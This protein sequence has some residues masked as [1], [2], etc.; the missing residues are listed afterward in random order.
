MARSQLSDRGRYVQVVI[1]STVAKP[2]RR[3]NAGTRR[4]ITGSIALLFVVWALIG[5]G[6]PPASTSTTTAVPS[7]PQ[8]QKA[9]QARVRA[10]RAK[11]AADLEVSKA[12]LVQVTNAL[13][14]LAT[15]IKAQRRA[16]ASADRNVLVA[17][18]SAKRLAA[19]V[20]R[21]QAELKALRLEMRRRAVAAYVNPPGDAVVAAL[22]GRDYLQASRQVF[23]VRLRQTSD[24]DLGRRLD[25]V[26]ELTQRRQSQARRARSLAVVDQKA[27][28]TALRKTELAELQQKQ[29]L[30]KVRATITSQLL[31]SLQLAATDREL[32]TKIAQQLALLQARLLANLQAHGG[33]PS[34]I[35]LCDVG[36][37]TVN[38]LIQAPVADM[39]A[40]AEHDGIHLT[41]GGYRNPAQ[42]IDLRRQH[43]GT[44]AYAI[45]DMPADQCHPPTARPGTSQHEIGLAIDFD[46]S[47]S[48]GS[49]GYQWLSAHAAQFGF[50]NL[51]TEPWHW[52]TTGS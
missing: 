25:S 15:N 12:S 24:A 33:L 14:V 34:A 27:R 19:S 29:L 23:F 39:L 6:S 5:A 10:E 48:R 8:E 22:A 49:V 40:T 20:H 47:R 21:L 43:C 32:S 42:Q 41:G 46:N 26:R 13:Q 35:Q 11:V 18:A 51:P 9:E 45:Y 7:D 28:N 37:I 38:C 2:R 52:S 36:G 31:H 3:V 44:D 4:R 1:W 30:A 17:T 50:Y 16:L